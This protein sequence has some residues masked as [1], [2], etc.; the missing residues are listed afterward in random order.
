ML[1][2]LSIDEAFYRPFLVGFDLILVI[3]DLESLSIE[4][5]ASL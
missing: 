5:G 4:I 2:S 1:S 3:H